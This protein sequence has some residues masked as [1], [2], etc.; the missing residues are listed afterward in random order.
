MSDDYVMPKADIGDI[1]LWYP[2]GET[3]QKPAPAI[4][5]DI[6]DRQLCLTIF[7]RD[8]RIPDPRTTVRHVTDP[9]LHHNHIQRKAGGWKHRPDKDRPAPK[10]APTPP[11]KA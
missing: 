7:M 2:E 5:T 4:V 11:S 6:S 1:V 9:L 3:T 10:P 8:A